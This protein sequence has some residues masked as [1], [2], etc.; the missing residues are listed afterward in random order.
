MQTK[1][2][3]FSPLWSKIKADVVSG[4]GY[5]LVML[6]QCPYLAA[7]LPSSQAASGKGSIHENSIPTIQSLFNTPAPDIY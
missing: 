1:E 5:F 2:T 7:E 3:S 4:K 6:P